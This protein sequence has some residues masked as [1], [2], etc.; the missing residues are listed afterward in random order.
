MIIPSIDLMNNKAVQLRQGKKK[1]LERDNPIDL[2][3]EFNKY[4]EIA[5]IDLDA[6]M[7]KGNNNTVIRQICCIANCRVG[8]GIHNVDGAKKLISWGASKIILGSKAFENDQINH[9]FLSSLN[10]AIS[11]Q[12]V[13]IA[14]DAFEGEIVTQAWQHR[15]GL[16]LFDVIKGLE[17]YASEFLYTCVEK[18]GGL[19]GTDLDTIKQLRK[20]TT[21][22]LTVAGGVTTIDEIKTLA[23]LGVDVQLGMAIYTGKIKMGDAFIESLNWKSNLIPTITSDDDGQ[24]LMLAYS[25]KDSLKKTFESGKMWYF[26]RSRNRLWMK[27]E[28]SQNIQQLIKIRNDCDSDALLATVKQQGNACHL[29][30]YSCFGDKKFSLN[31]LYKV[32]KDRLDNPIPDSYTATLTEKKLREK[33]LEEAEEVVI[34]R[35]K[36]EIIWEAADVLYFLSV[37]LAKSCVTID[38][39]LNELRRRRKQ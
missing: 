5:V 35:T 36:E 2:A 13:I 25:N 6:A 14:I 10:S 21:N 24:V 27:G 1:V 38:E 16:K 19:K 29:G 39:V 18:E 32:I 15:T 11:N 4:N 12:H 17:K 9:Q 28:T 3:R 22:Q 30:S 31:T 33:L 23:E 8:G 37:L 26:S 20:S 7:G 34:A